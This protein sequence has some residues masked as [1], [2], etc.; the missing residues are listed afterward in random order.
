MRLI[1]DP[2]E[3]KKTYQLMCEAAKEAE[4]SMCKKS[5][6]GVVIAKDWEIIA[7]GYNMATIPELCC[8]RKNIKDNSR[9]ELCSAIHAEQMAIAKATED[10]EGTIMYHIKVKDGEMK[11]SGKPSCTIC[12]RPIYVAGIKEFVLLHKE[13]YVA[14]SADYFNRI[15]FKYFIPTL[16]L[17]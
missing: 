8:L 5:K 12:S 14:Y 1:I 4:K 17:P 3:I 16:E 9:V 13:G 2:D 7:R 6:R 15:S 10:L 11:V